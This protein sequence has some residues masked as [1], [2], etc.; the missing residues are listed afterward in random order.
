M[1][2][3][4]V[5]TTF[6]RFAGDALGG[7]GNCFFD[8]YLELLKHA[9]VD[10]VAPLH[11]NSPRYEKLANLTIYREPPIKSYVSFESMIE[12]V[13]IFKIPVML[14]NMYRR[15]LNLSRQNDYDIVHGFFI[16]PAGFLISILPT[17]TTKI[18]SALGSDVHTLSYKPLM[19][20]LYRFIFTKIDGVIYN[21]LSMKNRLDQLQAKN[22]EYVPT[23]LDRRVF[24]LSSTLPKLPHFIF[25]GRLTKAKGVEVLLKAFKKVLAILPKAKLTIVGDGPEKLAMLKFIS[26]NNLQKSIRLVGTLA[27]SEI[28]A[29]LKNSYALLLPSFREGTPASVLEAM[30]VG[31]PIVATKVGGLKDLVTEEVGY[32]TDIGNIDQFAKAIIAVYK[33]DFVPKTIRNKTQKFDS[34]VVSDQYLRYYQRIKT[35]Y[36]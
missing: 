14:I 12:T 34:I 5:T 32:L 19:P 33:T 16:V 4:F 15:I 11:L 9:I 18:V 7:I 23:P 22:L 24:K 1:R 3:L 31:R 36:R 30:S 21:S 26:E 25:V 13:E 28:L 10:V 6:A 29:M 8:L 27:R 2:V 35:I 20:S 17:K